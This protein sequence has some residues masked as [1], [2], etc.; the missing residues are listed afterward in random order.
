MDI[1]ADAR[2]IAQLGSS[3]VSY[4]RREKAV[5]RGTG[6]GAYHEQLVTEV[7]GVSQLNTYA[8]YG[9]PG[10]DKHRFSQIT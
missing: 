5:K 2:Q 6:K 7:Y 1:K 9:K 10:H 4:K 8:A 3:D